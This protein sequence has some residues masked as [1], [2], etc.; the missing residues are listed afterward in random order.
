M[1]IGTKAP[2]FDLPDIDGKN[3]SLQSL[4]AGKTAIAIVFTCNHC[5][6]SVAY[7]ERLKKLQAQY[8]DKGV[9]FVAINPD[10]EDRHPEDTFDS[11]KKHAAEKGWNFHY[12]RDKTGEISG[13]YGAKVVPEVFLADSAGNIRYTGRIDDC[14]QSAKRVKRHDLREAIEDILHNRDV[15]VKTTTPIG[16]AI[17]RE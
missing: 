13:A 7:E 12:L 15:A 9:V 11:M 17:K 8:A 16:C 2:D 6:Y 5:P 14:W 1:R 4:A 3:T 10:N